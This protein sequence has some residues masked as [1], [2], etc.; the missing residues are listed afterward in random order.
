LHSKDNATNADEQLIYQHSHHPITQSPG[1]LN[2]HRTQSINQS[3]HIC[4]APYVANESEA[5]KQI[6]CNHAQ[7]YSFALFPFTQNNAA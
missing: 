4:V 3:K 2:H 1:K 5:H 7:E 6:I